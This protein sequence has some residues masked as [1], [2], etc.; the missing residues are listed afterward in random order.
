MAVPLGNTQASLDHGVSY[1]SCHALL[2][3]G[4]PPEASTTLPKDFLKDAFQVSIHCE[5][6][7]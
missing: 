7:M 5:V 3:A 4:D 1:F 6:L 2:L